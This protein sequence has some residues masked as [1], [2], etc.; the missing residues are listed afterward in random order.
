TTFRVRPRRCRPSGCEA[1]D[2]AQRPERFTRQGNA[3]NRPADFRM[4][5]LCKHPLFELAQRLRTGEND[6]VLATAS[7]VD[8]PVNLSIRLNTWQP[9]HF[10]RRQW[11]VGSL[12][13]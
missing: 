6:E 8:L 12:T 7:L 2:A 3:L 9:R 13:R 4:R 5:Q 1:A 10:A 11:V